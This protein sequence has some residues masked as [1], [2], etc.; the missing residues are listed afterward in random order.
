METNLNMK[1]DNSI[2]TVKDFWNNSPCNIRHSKS[3]LGTKKY[4]NEVESRKYFVEPHI[5]GFAEFEKWKG[6]KVL[7][8]GCGIGTDSIN[9][10]RAGAD[11]TC[12]ELSEKSL[13]IAKKRFKEF[14]L[15]ANFYCGN[16]EEISKFVPIEEYDLIYSFGVIHHTPNPSNVLNEIKKYTK[17]DTTIKIMMYSKYSWKTFSFFIKNGY[18]FGFSLD[19]T[20][21]Y[22]AEAQLNCPVAYTYTNSSIKELLCDFDIKEIKKDHIFPYIIKDYIKHKYKKT[23]IF[24]MIPNRMFKWLEKKLGWHYLITF[25][26][27]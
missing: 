15:E 4:F 9:F 8:I 21:Q 11:L 12:V 24:R 6:K 1:S 20:I 23:F 27:K 19:K 18:K 17:K 5:P 14:G 2:N 25:K 16:A 22:F 10:A 7:E 13:D 3:K 26:I